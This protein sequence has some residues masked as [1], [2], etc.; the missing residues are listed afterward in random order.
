MRTFVL[1]L[2]TIF[3]CAC[4]L[5]SPATPTEYQSSNSN[6]IRETSQTNSNA[7]ALVRYPGLASPTPQEAR[8]TNTEAGVR[9]V[10]FSNFTFNWYPNWEKGQPT[11]KNITL[12]NGAMKIDLPYAVNAPRGF[13]LTSV[14][15]ADLTGD[16][17]EDAIVVLKITTRA[18]PTP[19]CIFVY[20]LQQ[21]VLKMVFVRET[22][23]QA[24]GGLRKVYAQE[25]Q[26]ILE[27]YKPDTITVNGQ[28][29]TLDSSS[30]YQRECYQWGRNEFEK[31]CTEVFPNQ[32]EDSAPWVVAKPASPP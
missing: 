29:V 11:R 15:Y 16:G 9:N 32:K 5:T 2:A 28:A 19:S 20:A 7:N 8:H 26:L 14:D 18:N 12:R 17:K 25:Q 23:D 13:D 27:T 10:D 22:G 1:V 21:N 30:T 6:I 24:F 4:Q 31:T 3:Q